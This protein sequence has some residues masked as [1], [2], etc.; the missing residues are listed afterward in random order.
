[1]TLIVEP[2][3]KMLEVHIMREAKAQNSRNICS[4]TLGAHYTQVIE[5]WPCSPADQG[6]TSLHP[7][8]PILCQ[9]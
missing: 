1:M 2:E 5:T 9:D 3:Y 8:S 6:V 7:P 4:L